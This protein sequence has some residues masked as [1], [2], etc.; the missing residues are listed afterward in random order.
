MSSRIAFV[1]LRPHCLSPLLAFSLSAQN[2]CPITQTKQF[3]TLSAFD[4]IDPHVLV[5]TIREKDSNSLCVSKY[6]PRPHSS[7]VTLVAYTSRDV[8]TGVDS[9]VLEHRKRSKVRSDLVCK[10]HKIVSKKIPGKA[11][12][13][14][15]QTIWK[16]KSYNPRTIR[17]LLWHKA[18]N[19][20][21]LLS[22]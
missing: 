17:V 7:H 8:Q 2:L 1:C 22:L 14:S 21:P 15:S 19:H 12:W 4:Q 5:G 16:N 6:C 3:F 20:W 9:K 11:H 18:T 13:N 10:H